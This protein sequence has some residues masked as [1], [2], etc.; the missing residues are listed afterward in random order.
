MFSSTR[1]GD[2]RCLH[3]D[4]RYAMHSAG[5]FQNPFDRCSGHDARYR[6][7]PRTTKRFWPASTPLRQHH[8]QTGLTHSEKRTHSWESSG[9]QHRTASARTAAPASRATDAA[10][11]D[12]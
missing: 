2:F 11:S 5:Q 12:G 7:S 3:S 10:T 4:Q 9:W 8:P 6:T 1:A